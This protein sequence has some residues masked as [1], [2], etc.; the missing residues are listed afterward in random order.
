[1][2]RV[3]YTIGHSNYGFEDFTSLLQLHSI[4]VVVDVRSNPYSRYAKHFTGTTLKPLLQNVG[5]K[6][7]FLGKEIGGKPSDQA[8]YDDDGFVQYDLIADTPQFQQG[9]TRLQTG[10]AK[11]RVAIMCGEENPSGCHRRNLIGKT[12]LERGIEVLHIRKG[13]IVHSEA[14]LV[15]EETGA[16]P[17]VL[18]LNLFA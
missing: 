5:F 8:M 13:G 15:F 16:P 9:M 14:D 1:M 18:Q 4:E 3:L 17:D 7:V 6:Y 10:L 2:E 11:F 12:A